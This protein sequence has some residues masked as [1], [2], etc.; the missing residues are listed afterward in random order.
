MAVL[1][2]SEFELNGRWYCSDTS[3]LGKGSAQWWYLPRMLNIS[4][5]AFVD[6]LIKDFH[7]DYIKYSQEHD[8]L[9]YSWRKQSDMRKFKNWANAQARKANFII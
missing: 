4:P 1:K 6:M 3:A 5:V 2:L 7:P 9:I 8:V